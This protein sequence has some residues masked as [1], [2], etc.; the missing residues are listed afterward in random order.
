M[1]KV[2]I[3]G[4]TYSIEKVEDYTGTEGRWGSISFKKAEIGLDDRLNIDVY[5]QTLIHEILHG[6]IKE[7][8]ID[9]EDEEEEMI[10]DKMS[11][12]L[13]QVLSDNDFSFLNKHV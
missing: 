3:G 10:V 12:V 1:D 8:C 2:K 7:S 9:L 11:K 6:I 13:F 4:I 5:N